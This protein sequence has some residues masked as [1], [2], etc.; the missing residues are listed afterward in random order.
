M[1]RAVI[2]GYSRSPFTMA[3]KGEL[4]DIKPVNLLAEVINNLVSKTKVNKSDIEDIVIGCAFQVGE[5]CFNIGKLVTFLTDM[6]IKTSGMTVDRWC[7]SSMEAIHIAAG[8]ISM[9]SGKVFICGGVE[10]MTR[11]NT[12]FDPMPYPYTEKENPNVYFSMG[13]TAE[14]VAKQYSIT[15]KEQQEF[16]ISSHTKAFEAQ[17]KGNFTR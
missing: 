4:I 9:G 3:R 7:G 6:D 17:S 5:Q 8:K 10:S 2:A 13:I 11:V 16:A 15:R 12:G 1:Y 14:N